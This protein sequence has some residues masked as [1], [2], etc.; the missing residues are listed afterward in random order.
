MTTHL[1]VSRLSAIA[2]RGPLDF[3]S[4]DVWV[5][6]VKRFHQVRAMIPSRVRESPLSNH[7]QTAR[8]VDIDPARLSPMLYPGWIAILRACVRD[9]PQLTAPVCRVRRRA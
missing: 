3:S 6:L 4:Q 9:V 8:F 7:L 2:A 1:Q 5:R